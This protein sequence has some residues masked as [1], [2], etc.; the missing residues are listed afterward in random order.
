MPNKGNSNG[1]VF[2]MSREPPGFNGASMVSQASANKMSA[3]SE[4][5]AP[6]LS[7]CIKAVLAS[8]VIAGLSH[9]EFYRASFDMAT[10][11]ILAAC[12]S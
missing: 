9:R 7:F 1:T 11:A 3:I 2:S 5:D 8:E 6:T 4:I 12:A 10:N